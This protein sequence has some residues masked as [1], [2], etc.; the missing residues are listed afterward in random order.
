M[1]NLYHHLI[2][3]IL[4]K[5]HSWTFWGHRYLC[6]EMGLWPPGLSIPEDDCAFQD[7]TASLL[8]GIGMIHDDTLW[9][10]NGD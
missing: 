3:G 4:I 6:Q 2:S 1:Y 9:L 7:T 10:I 8:L 5:F